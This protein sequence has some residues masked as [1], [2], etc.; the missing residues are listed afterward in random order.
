M[1][2]GDA[3]LTESNQLQCDE[4]SLTGESLPSEKNP[5]KLP[6]D[7]VLGDQ[8]KLFFKGSSVTNG[9]GKAFII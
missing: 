1:I 7:T 6:K 8:V 9:Y 3:H 2:P 4:S 5:E